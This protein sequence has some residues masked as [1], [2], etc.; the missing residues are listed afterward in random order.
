MESKRQINEVDDSL[1]VLIDDGIVDELR[2]SIERRLLSETP[3]P[4]TRCIFKVP[5]KIRLKKPQAYEP[6]IVSIGPY[7]SGPNGNSGNKFRL[8]ENVKHWYLHCL[9]SRVNITLAGLIIGV[10][11]LDKRARDYYAEPLDHLKK[12]DFLDMMILDGCFLIELF[13]KG[14]HHYDI[15]DPVYSVSCTMEYLYH[16]L[17]LLENQLP[18]FVL[19]RLYNLTAVENTTRQG[20]APSLFDLVL[21]FFTKIIPNKHVLRPK[22]PHKILHI[23]DVIRAVIV[24][25]FEPPPKE[26]RKDRELPQTIPNVTTL[27]KAGIQFQKGSSGCVLDINFENGVFT[28]PPLPF[29]EITE[30]LFR[31]LIAFEQCHHKRRHKITSYAVLMESCIDSSKD[32]DLLC[33]RQILGNWLSAQDAAQFFNLLYNDTTVDGFYY[34]GLCAKVN[35][36]YNSKWNKWMGMLWRDYLDTPWTIISLIAAFILLVLTTLQTVYTMHQ[37]YHPPN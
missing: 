28:I 34:Q 11:D 21:T 31:N 13:R 1:S 30:P 18:W 37:Y 12:K 8:M 19:E 22:R 6:D 10:M 26:E 7:H 24:A 14:P 27:S 9:L 35:E 20:N 17:I 16:D 29:D 15:N 4:A 3:M 25:P 36:Y 33:D 32:I 2:N 23:L 5:D